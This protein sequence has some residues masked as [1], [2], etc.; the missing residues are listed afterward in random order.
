[1]ETNKK[2]GFAFLLNLLFSVLEA[3]GG[4]ITGSVAILSD[5]VHDFGD[6]VSIGVS[7]ICEKVACKKPDKT[8]TYGYARFSVLG[9]LVTNLILLIGSVLVAWNAVE[10]LIS[11]VAVDS[12]GMIAL[13]GA[14]LL[15][16]GVAVYFTHGGKSINQKAVNLH[17]LEDLLGWIVVL[18]GAIVMRFTNFTIL[19]P[20]MSIGV[21]IFILVHVVKNLKEILDLFLEKT[22]KNINPTEIKEHLLRIDGIIEVHHVHVWSLDGQN[23]YATMHIVAEGNPHEIKDRARQELKEHGIGHVTLELESANEHCHEKNCCVTFSSHAH[24]HH[25]HHHH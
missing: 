14:G 12:D 7:Y 6:A 16:N 9:G 10:R 21:A 25:H 17:M 15:V 13:A 8:Y 24:H 20:L 3:V 1:M 18:I 19:D 23:H 2:I 22:P 11:P 5:A 4:I